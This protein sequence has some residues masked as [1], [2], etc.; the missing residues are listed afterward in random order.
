[1]R[2]LEGLVLLQSHTGR[3]HPLTDLP[4]YVSVQ[5]TNMLLNPKLLLYK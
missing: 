5:V 1:M 3:Q 2:V 4:G